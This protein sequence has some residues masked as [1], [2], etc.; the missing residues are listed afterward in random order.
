M[1]NIDDLNM[2]PNRKTRTRIA[3]VVT[4]PDG[5]KAYFRSVGA[6]SREFGIPAAKLKTI[7]ITKLALDGKTF[8][9]VPASTVEEYLPKRL[10]RHT[11]PRKRRVLVSGSID[12]DDYKRLMDISLRTG[13]SRPKLVRI[14]IEN[15]IASE[16]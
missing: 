4:D 13:V 5:S 7:A 15:Y 8:E 16:E 3:V 11:L 1:L 6:A 10:R 9:L 14:A 2:L 12:Q